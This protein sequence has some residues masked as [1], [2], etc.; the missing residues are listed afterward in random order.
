MLKTA[1]AGNHGKDVRSDCCVDIELTKSGGIHVEL[2]SKVD[3]LFGQANRQLITKGLAYFDI[4]NARV[5]IDDSGALPYIMMA[6]LEAALHQL[7]AT[8]KEYL[9]ELLSENC[10]T[11]ARD[12]Q[13]RSRLY[14]PG[15]TPKLFINAGLHKADG[16]ILDL[17]DSVAP[18]KKDEARY[19]VRNALR[20]NNFYGCERMVRINQGQRGLEDLDYIVPHYVNVIL[21][22]KCEDTE[23]L[24]GIDKKIQSIKKSKKLDYPVYFM[25]IIESAKG[26]IKGVIKKYNVETKKE[27]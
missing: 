8:E 19:L 16:I 17:E 27:R 21:V 11:T 9:P 20:A 10:Y 1:A 24:I 13:R 26:V 23:Y 15:N 7:I 3:A 12:R 18:A 6:R 2:I 5:S 14:L 25:P 22:P 4:K